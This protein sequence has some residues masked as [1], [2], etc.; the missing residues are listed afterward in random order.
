MLQIIG[1]MVGGY[2]LFRMVDAICSVDR[3]V[4]VKSCAIIVI[5]FTGL[6]MFGMIVGGIKTPPIP[7]SMMR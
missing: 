3:N 5:G 4:F 1:L 7:P 6:C 2:I